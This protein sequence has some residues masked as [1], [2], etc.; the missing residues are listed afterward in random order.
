MLITI[1][2][3]ANAV[4]ALPLAKMSEED[5]ADPEFRSADFQLWYGIFGRLLPYD[6]VKFAEIC[7]RAM[8]AGRETVVMLRWPFK[9]VFEPLHITQQWGLFAVV[10]EE[11]DRLVIEVRRN[12]EWETLYRRLDGSHDW[13]DPQLKYR[14]IRGVWDGVKDEP[15]GTYKRLTDWVSRVVFA[16]QP[17]VD[18]VRVVLEKE[19]KTLPWV[20]NDRPTKRRA[21]RYHKR[22]EQR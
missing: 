11:P 8:W 6:E 17:D 1:V 18:R 9:P 16:E 19:P 5:L 14:R 15:K 12:K 20:E 22:E 7:R 13:H 2:L 10:T 3:V 4:H 21:E